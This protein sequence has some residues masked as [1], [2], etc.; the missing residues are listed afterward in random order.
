MAQKQH[1]QTLKQ[2]KDLKPKVGE[3]LAKLANAKWGREEGKDGGLIKKKS[4]YEKELESFYQF[5]KGIEARH[6]C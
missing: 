1:K 4:E 5:G 6:A 3:A 2:I